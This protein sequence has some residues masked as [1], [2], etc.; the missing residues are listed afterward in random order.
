MTFYSTRRLH[1]GK[2]RF[3]YSQYNFQY[4]IHCKIM[5][6]LFLDSIIKSTILFHNTEIMCLCGLAETK[7]N[8]LNPTRFLMLGQRELALRLKEMK[9]LGR[10]NPR[11]IYDYNISTQYRHTQLHTEMCTPYKN[12]NCGIWL[13]IWM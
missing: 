13:S 7:I 12:C 9:H 3:L 8:I 2:T 11:H 6:F 10:I 5:L 1:Y 4:N